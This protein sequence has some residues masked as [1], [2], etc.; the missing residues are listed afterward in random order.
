M[1]T[2]TSSLLGGT[3]ATGVEASTLIDMI[4]LLRY[5]EVYGE[6]RRGVTV[7]KIRGSDHDKTIREFVIGPHGVAVGAPFRT[8]SGIL[9]GETLQLATDETARVGVMFPEPLETSG[10][11]DAR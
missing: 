7:L 9:A 5:V 1:T 11:A 10:P 6:L 2:T 3:S 8:T 4:V